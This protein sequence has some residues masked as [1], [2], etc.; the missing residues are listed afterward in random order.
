MVLRPQSLRCL[1]KKTRRWEETLTLR[2]PV[3]PV[4]RRPRYFDVLRQTDK[5]WKLEDSL[6]YGYW[7]VDGNRIIF[8]DWIGFTKS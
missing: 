1:S 5:F 2:D 8:E 4:N 7:N 6:I 3:G